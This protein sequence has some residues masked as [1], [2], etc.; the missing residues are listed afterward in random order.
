MPGLKRFPA[1]SAGEDG[2]FIFVGSF[3]FPAVGPVLVAGDHVGL[4]VV[5]LVLRDDVVMEA[6]NAAERQPVRGELAKISFAYCSTESFL[7]A[8]ILDYV[9]S[10]SQ[11]R[12]SCTSVRR[13]ACGS[14]K[15]PIS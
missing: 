9:Y 15:R 11:T 4:P 6:R 3:P 5:L 1:F 10:V 12:K 8:F 14:S 13:R 7:F 2:G